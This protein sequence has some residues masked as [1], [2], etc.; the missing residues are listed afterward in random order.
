MEVILAPQFFL[1]RIFCMKV[2]SLGSI[3][4]QLIS[5][6]REGALLGTTSQGVFLRVTGDRVLF[7]TANAERG[8][9]TLNLDGMLRGLR[10]GPGD[11]VRIAADRL[12]FAKTG[13]SI[14]LQDASEW[15]PPPCAR[16]LLSPA[17]RV[18]RIE[19]VARLV[20]VPLDPDTAALLSAV[21]YALQ[22]S[23]QE[24]AAARVGRLLGCGS[25]LTPDGDDIVL[26]LLLALNRWRHRFAAEL[27]VEAINT[28][29]VHAARNKT[30]ALSASLIACAAQGQADERLVTGLDGLMTGVPGAQNCAD[31]FNRWG[32]SSGGNVFFGIRAALS[33]LPELIFIEGNQT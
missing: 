13:L 20:G 31:V 30:T 11:P 3:A 17:E 16:V 22:T 26:G 9:L 21:S 4:R 19:T 23:Q 29:L 32:S 1:R 25:G 2:L 12:W 7:L 8:P 14:S 15:S 6:S 5:Q 10:E 24:Q 33:V 18:L 28:R 27:A